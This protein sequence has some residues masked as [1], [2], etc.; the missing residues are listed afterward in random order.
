MMKLHTV[1][2]WGVTVD[3]PQQNGK[4]ISGAGRVNWGLTL[5]PTPVILTLTATRAPAAID[6]AG[7]RRRKLSV[8][9]TDGRTDARP[10]RRPCSTC[11]AGIVNEET[12]Y[13]ATL[14]S[15]ICN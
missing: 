9:G 15:R 4:N 1:K 2:N 10:L 3:L 6:R 12:R 11:C 8:D 13:M 7:T 5:P 14:L